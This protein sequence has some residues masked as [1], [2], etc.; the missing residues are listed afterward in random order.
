MLGDSYAQLSWTVKDFS[1]IQN[2]FYVILDT[3]GALSELIVQL[4]L[5]LNHQL[6][7]FYHVARL[8]KLNFSF[9]ISHKLLASTIA[10]LYLGKL[11][12]SCEFIDKSSHKLGGWRAK[13]CDISRKHL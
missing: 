7:G 10:L 2:S 5:N 11:I 3:S 13:V 1:P 8:N 9:K 4:L 12:I 6:C